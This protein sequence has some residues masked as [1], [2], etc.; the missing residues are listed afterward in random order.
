MLNNL[1]DWSCVNILSLNTDKTK[2]VLFYKENS[3][4]NLP[5]VLPDLYI[6]DVKTKREKSLKF[7]G[8]MNDNKLEN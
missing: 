1:N 3:E 7:L 5:Q 8:F 2:Y 6:N 4:D